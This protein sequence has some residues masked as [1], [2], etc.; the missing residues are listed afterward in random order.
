MYHMLVLTTSV[1]RSGSQLAA[2]RVLLF[3]LST[4][5]EGRVDI[6]LRRQIKCDKAVYSVATFG[7]RYVPLW[8][9]NLNFFS[10]VNLE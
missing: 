4:F 1:T 5:A 2:G 10:S 3:S 8:S 7:A 9:L 6:R